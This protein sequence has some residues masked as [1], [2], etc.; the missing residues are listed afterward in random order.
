MSPDKPTDTIPPAQV[1]TATEIKENKQKDNVEETKQEA[2]DQ[3]Q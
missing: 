2:E 3:K 1:R